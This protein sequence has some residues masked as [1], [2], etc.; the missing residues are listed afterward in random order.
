MANKTVCIPY[1]G[2]ASVGAIFSQLD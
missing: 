2:I 1:E